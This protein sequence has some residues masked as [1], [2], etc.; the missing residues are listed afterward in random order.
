MRTVAIVGNAD[1][2]KYAPFEDLSKEIWGI[3]E[4]CPNLKRAT[5]W[6]QLHTPDVWRHN[7]KD[8][9]HLKKLQRSKIPVY[10]QEHYEDIPNSVAFPKEIIEKHG[11]IFGSTMDYLMALAVE[12][13]FERIELYGIDLAIYTEYASQKPSFMYF[14][15]LARGLGIDVFIH[16]ESGLSVDQL[17]GFSTSNSQQVEVL[18]EEIRKYR[19]L[20]LE[21]VETQNLAKGMYIGL[22]TISE[23]PNLDVQGALRSARGQIAKVEE[24]IKSLDTKK[25]DLITALAELT[26]ATVEVSPPEIEVKI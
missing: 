9:H 1:S 23:T 17:Y 25:Q 8:K 11:H 26:G 14:V 2:K 10:M 4:W 15:G 13:G 20:I 6:F 7:K 5:R 19:L 22:K 24:L 12:E 16:P 18:L 21:A 3:N